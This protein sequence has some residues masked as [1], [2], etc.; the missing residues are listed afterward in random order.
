[1]ESK[2]R[3][4]PLL[5]ALLDRDTEVVLAAMRS[6]KQTKDER[7]QPSVTPLLSH[8]NQAV[9]GSAALFLEQAGW[10]PPAGPEAIQFFIARGQMAKAAAVG[11]AAIPALEAALRTGP[12][13]HRV[14]ALEA[15]AR[16][17]DNGTRPILLD[18]LKSEEPAVCAAAVSTLVGVL[19]TDAVE[20]ILPMLRHAHASVRVAAI[21]AL[22][23]LGVARAV[24]PITLM[25]R[26]T[27]WE[28]RHAAAD[29][30]G[31]MKAVGAADALVKALSDSDAD[32]REVTA[33]ALGA[34]RARRSIGALVKALSDSNAGVRRIAASS[35]SRIDEEW[36]QSPEA[37]TAI[38]GLKASLKSKDSDVRHA[39]S[40]LL[41]SLGAHTPGI[42]E[43]APAPQKPA[44]ATDRNKLATNLFI[45]IL[46]DGDPLLRM[47]AA[48]S[49]GRIG[50]RLGE[51][52]LQQSLRDPNSGVRA[53]A[54]RALKALR[55]MPVP[56]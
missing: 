28:V 41:N 47:A 7:I 4:D 55:E 30:L 52:P 44:P 19:G 3:I 40:A 39:V 46:C 10:I 2:E 35:L 5:N 34:L 20:P 36:S 26:D 32:V 24:D 43:P 38:E 23:R 27:V 25:L 50:D 53:S 33:R 11:V 9:R 29:A 18:A 14:A 15:L 22:A 31:K 8:E 6:L 51:S 12:Y 49:L 56:I 48:E 37:K 45:S 17:R 16:I 1:L 13:N 42:M 54:E 21:E